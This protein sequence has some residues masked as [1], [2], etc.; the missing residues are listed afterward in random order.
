MAM[1]QGRPSRPGD[2]TGDVPSDREAGEGGFR[3]VLAN[4]D[5]RLIWFAQVAAQLADKF[6]MFSLII[7]AYRLWHG[8]TSV[9]GGA[10]APIASRFEIYAPY[11]TAVVLFAVAGGLIGFARIPRPPRRAVPSGDRHGPFVTLAL[12]VKS[13]AEALGSSPG[14]LLAF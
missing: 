13:G 1:P 4:R 7:L 3:H 12:D 11:W 2:G 5:F 10:L 9:L 8:S 14:L 6:L